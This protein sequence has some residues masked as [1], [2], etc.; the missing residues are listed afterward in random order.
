MAKNINLTRSPVNASHIAQ[1]TAHEAKRQVRPWVVGLA[2]MGFAAKGIVYG[3]I[4]FLALRAA[5]GAGGQTTNSQGALYQIAQQPFGRI[6]LVCMGLGLI[7][8]ALW[9]FVQAAVDPENKGSDA[10]GTMKRIGYAVS[11]FIHC[12]LAFSAFGIVLGSAG[13]SSAGGSSAGGGSS[14]QHWTAKLLAQPLGQWLVGIVGVLIFG[15]GLYSC[16]LAYNAK[17][18]EKL[19]LAQMS[20]TEDTWITRAGRLG[21]CAR[22]LLLGIIGW[23]FMRTAQQADPGQSGGLDRA[24]DMLANQ[25]HGRWLLGGVAVGLIA[26]GLYALAEARYRRIYL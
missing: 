17:F 2:R 4:G 11:G 5:L 19:N 20:H 12:G 15:A 24:L 14:Q 9:R 16:Y 10:K 18:R 26:Y 3:V 22:G 21:L 8:Y 7:G 1:Q 13:G 23:F 6:L 25:L